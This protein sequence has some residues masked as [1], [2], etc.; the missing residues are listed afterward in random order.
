MNIVNSFDWLKALKAEYISEGNICRGA[1]MVVNNVGYSTNGST[2]F[3]AN[4]N[5][6]DEGCYDK[7]TGE[8]YNKFWMLTPAKLDKYF[9]VNKKFI[10][11]INIE[12]DFTTFKRKGLNFDN[13]YAMLDEYEVYVLK[14]DLDLAISNNIESALYDIEGEKIIIE[15][16]Y[17]FA[18][19]RA[20]RAFKG[21]IRT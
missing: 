4:V 13:T 15:N 14:K 20:T 8:K 6:L 7:I 5:A 17:G 9:N 3:K 2:L 10:S 21:M 1:V 19:L 11:G 18:F 12:T 16:N